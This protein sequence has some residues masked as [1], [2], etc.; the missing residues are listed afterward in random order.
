MKIK[1]IFNIKGQLPI[2]D[3]YIMGAYHYDR[4]PKGNGEMG[5]N[6][7]VSQK[8][9]GSDFNPD[10]S[11]RMYHGD[12]IPG[13]PYHPHRGFEIVTY[14]PIGYADHCDSRGSRGRYGQGD[15]QLMSA[16]KGVLHSEMFPLIHDDKENPLRLFQIWLNLPAKSKLTEPDY[17]MIWAEQLPEGSVDGGNGTKVDVKVL[18]GNYNG[19]QSVQPL[20]NSWAADPNN[21]VGIATLE[22]EAGSTFKLPAVTASLSRF[23]FFYEGNGQITIEGNPMKS[24]QMA[25]LNGA[26]EIEITNGNQPAKILILEGEPIGEPVAAHGP[27]VMNT[28]EELQTSFEEYQKTQF[29]GWPWGPTERDMVNPKDAGRFA[30]Y[31]F[32]QVIDRPQQ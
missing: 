25:D 13:F 4:Y 32:D 26:E 29:G 11:W 16:G 30:S 1:Q 23:L 28:Y 21:H 7:D 10:A 18:L 2:R 6:V 3:P 17:K 24:N 5:P 31:D 8:A 15:V 12:K 9:N 27:F 20:T 14:V 19:I 22:M